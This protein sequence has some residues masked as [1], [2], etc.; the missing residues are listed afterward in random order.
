MNTT[1]LRDNDRIGCRNQKLLHHLISSTHEL[2]PIHRATGTTRSSGELASIATIP[3]SATIHYPPQAAF[4]FPG[5]LFTNDDE[6]ENDDGRETPPHLRLPMIPWTASMRGY[7]FTCWIQLSHSR[8]AQMAG[9]TSVDL[10]AHV[11]RLMHQDRIVLACSLSQFLSKTCVI[12]L[13]SLQDQDHHRRHDVSSTSRT[14]WSSVFGGSGGGSSTTTTKGKSTYRSVRQHIPIQLDQWHHLVLAHAA[15]YVGQDSVEVYVDGHLV[16]NDQELAFPD[17]GEYYTCEVGGGTTQS[18]M[19]E[20]VMYDGRLT[21]ETIE[22]LYSVGP[23][24]PSNVLRSSFVPRGGGGGGSSFGSLLPRVVHPQDH[25]I[26]HH[27]NR[28]SSS[29]IKK[30]HLRQDQLELFTESRSSSALL[31]LHSKIIFAYDA[32]DEG[33]ERRPRG[34]IFICQSDFMMAFMPVVRH[35]HFT[36]GSSSSSSG[37]HHPSLAQDR[38]IVFQG[39]SSIVRSLST[40]ASSSC[41]YR[42]RGILV[43]VYLLDECYRYSSIAGNN[44]DDPPTTTT[45]MNEEQLMTLKTCLQWIHSFMHMDVAGTLDGLEHF[46]FHSLAWVLIQH[47]VKLSR[48]E[49][50][51]LIQF[52]ESFRSSKSKNALDENENETEVYLLARQSLLFLNVS[53]WFEQTRV[54]QRQFLIYH[55]KSRLTTRYAHDHAHC[56]VLDVFSMSCR[57]EW[58]RQTHYDVDC[59]DLF[60]QLIT[61]HVQKVKVIETQVQ[62]L[63]G[64]VLMHCDACCGDSSSLENSSHSFGKLCNFVQHVFGQQPSPFSVDDSLNVLGQYDE[65][66]M[67]ERWSLALSQQLSCIESLICVILVPLDRKGKDKRINAP[68]LS[69]V[70]Q[71]LYWIEEH[72]NACPLISTEKQLLV[73]KTSIYAHVLS[74]RALGERENIVLISAFV[75][76]WLSSRAS[77]SFHFPFILACIPHVSSSPLEQQQLFMELVLK[78]KTS[79]DQTRVTICQTSPWVH[80]L[81]SLLARSFHT[82]TSVS[83]SSSSSSH[84]NTCQDLVWECLLVLFLSSMSLE[85]GWKFWL[86]LLVE[87]K[88]AFVSDIIEDTSS[89]SMWCSSWS[90]LS[91][92]TQH[93]LHKLAHERPI[94]TRALSHNLAQVLHLVHECCVQHKDTLLDDHRGQKLLEAVMDMT[95]FLLDSTNSSHREGLRFALS[96]LQH[97]VGLLLCSRNSTT[98]QDIP[99]HVRHFFIQ[100]ALGLLERAFTQEINTGSVMHIYPNT[101]NA[102]LN[103]LRWS[104]EIYVLME[105]PVIIQRSLEHLVTTL[106]RTGC[107]DYELGTSRLSLLSTVA[108]IFDHLQPSFT[109]MIDSTTRGGSLIARED[110]MPNAEL[111]PQYQ[112]IRKDHHHSSILVFVPK[113]DH[114]HHHLSTNVPTRVVEFFQFHTFHLNLRG[115]VKKMQW[116][117]TKMCDQE[118]LRLDALEHEQNQFQASVRAYWTTQH[119]R[120]ESELRPRV[121]AHGS[122]SSSSSQ[123]LDIHHERPFPGRER[124]RLIPVHH[125]HHHHRA[126]AKIKTSKNQHHV[127][128][129]HK[130]QPVFAHPK[131]VGPHRS[132]YATIII[133]SSEA[134]W[135][136]SA[137]SCRQILPQGQVPGVI[138]VSHTKI[139]FL[140]QALL[141]SVTE[142][143]TL[144]TAPDDEDTSRVHHVVQEWPLVSLEALLLRCYRL[145]DSA[146]ELFLENGKVIFLDIFDSS[147][148]R[149]SVVA[150]IASS[151]LV[152]S[153]RMAIQHLM[154]SD[155]QSLVHALV[156]QHLQLWQQRKISNFEYLMA[157]NTFSGRSFNDLSQYPVVSCCLPASISVCVFLIIISLSRHPLT[158]IVSLDSKRLLVS[159]ARP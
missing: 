73:W 20:I 29:N 75:S 17:S 46:I 40:G 152:C 78:L 48:D 43:L 114:H 81:L 127:F 2:D 11:F 138:Y 110:P 143:H 65:D 116:Q 67:I 12:D 31:D 115:L 72:D 104:H 9:L 5:S 123:K 141:G 85:H 145:R 147:V 156:Q 56:N 76:R 33:L 10:D 148:R 45:T 64:L 7:T 71:V 44:D 69:F 51:H 140:P 96:S 121:V 1:R 62:A 55:L 68:L 74:S 125:H 134:E 142:E 26:E 14:L 146:F 37:H 41:L 144:D 112:L 82:S 94:L 24:N 23:N 106:V 19:S 28:P 49:M 95:D 38:R 22:R 34:D 59:D 150:C 52:V 101:R 86:Q 118:H 83:S 32:L 89:R 27:D 105:C 77:L 139:V 87:W 13:Q 54:V 111:F 120:F 63:V 128:L 93:V 137:V 53:F 39:H 58:A 90:T 153:S 131:Y 98:V 129:S 158:L 99:E 60:Y 97:C 47:K 70:M 88:E 21:R 3:S 79:V 149:A 124:Q 155:D 66:Q 25:Q 4:Y 15:H 151:P 100:R 6:D 57:R 122:S 135:K 35:H 107:L 132:Y 136:I 159:R 102:L 108:D 157:L 130:Q 80:Q 8:A 109:S 103:L 36:S 119:A 84:N 30:N 50:T 92:L 126:L 42:Y 61:T 133:N 117:R 18:W 91:R 113:D 16:V 154:P